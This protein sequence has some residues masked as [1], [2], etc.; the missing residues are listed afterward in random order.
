MAGRTRQT[1]ARVKK[2]SR[3]KRTFGEIRL[4]TEQRSFYRFSILAMQINRCITGAYISKF[5]RPAHAWKVLTLLGR[6]GSMSVTEINQHTTLEMDKL[7]RILDA[8]VRGKLVVRRRS[9]EDRR[10]TAVS[11]STKG[12]KVALETERMIADMERQFLIILSPREREGLYSTFDKLQERADT[13]FR[14]KEPWSRFL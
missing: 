1:T 14:G 10:V 11:L 12:K 7:T 3:R 4:Q 6:F 9:T 13:L 5:G 2:A 8:L